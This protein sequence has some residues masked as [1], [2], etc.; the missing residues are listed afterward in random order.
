MTLLD[1]TFKGKT[2][3]VT[4]HT[5]FKG[6]WLCQWLLCLDAKV[7]GISQ[8]IP[9][10]PSNFDV[11]GLSTKVIDFRADIR[12]YIS[13]SKIITEIKPDF[14]FHLA[15]QP[16]VQLSYLDPIDT[17]SSN[18]LGTVN[19]L[20]SLRSLSNDCVC[21]MITS[22]K[23]YHNKEWTWGYREIDSLG[24]SD[25]YSASKGCAEIAI[26]SYCDS[27]FP[28]NGLIR[29]ASARAGNVIGGGDWASH[30]LIP[31]C[32]RAWNVSKNIMLRNP[33]ST[34]PWQH[35]LEPLSGY[36]LLAVSL[37]ADVSLHGESFNFGPSSFENYSVLNLVEE[38]SRYWSCVSWNIDQSSSMKEESILLK[39]NCDKAFDL[40]KWR[41]V[42]TFSDTVRFTAEWY[43]L[44][45]SSNDSIS[46]F[47]I[48][49]IEEFTSKAQSIFVPWSM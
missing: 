41:P 32:V 38:F 45:Y 14:I 39:L 9:S 26:H 24:G 35:V 19:I 40:L 37:A 4:G 27:F 43:N 25:P 6:S 23:C 30:R 11:L 18:V 28:R 29:V 1:Q 46:H 20:D 49:Q 31:D 44:Y 3:L 48:S 10:I 33:S 13:I 21:I 22:D 5:G 12:D 17:W 47:S 7:V 8:D 2:V 42:L 36:L 34:R 16:I 15:A